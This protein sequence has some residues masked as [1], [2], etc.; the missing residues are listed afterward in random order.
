M[1]CRVGLHILLE[2]SLLSLTNV[3][4]V[5]GDVMVNI[6]PKAMHG[7]IV[8]SPQWALCARIKAKHLHA[9][10]MKCALFLGWCRALEK[11]LSRDVDR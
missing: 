6:L 5:Y 2:C 4:I 10:A 1:S 9:A 7:T 8:A 11:H 3:P